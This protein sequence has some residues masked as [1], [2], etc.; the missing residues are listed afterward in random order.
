MHILVPQQK[1]PVLESCDLLVCGAGPGGVCAAVAAARRGARTVLLERWS[2]AGG[3]GTASLLAVWHTSDRTRQVIWGLVNEIFE[4]GSRHGWCRRLAHYPAYHETHEFDI[5]GLK[6][7]YDDL[8]TEAGVRVYYTLPAGDVVMDGA[9]IAAVLCDTKTGRKAIVPRQVI[10]ATGDGDIAAKAGAPFEVGRAQDGRV[11][12]MTLIYK[13]AGIDHVPVLKMSAAEHQ[14]ILD[15]MAAA[16]D[17]GELP[18][19]GPVSLGSYALGGYPNMNPCSGDP[20]DEAS[21]TRGLMQTRRQMHAYVEFWRRHAPGFANARVDFSA[22]ALGV[23]ESRRFLCRETLTAEDVRTRRKRPDAIG[24]GVWMVDIHDPLGSGHTT[25]QDG[26]YEPAGTSYHIPFG[27]LVPK[28]V[29]NLLIACRAAGSTHEGHASVRVMS[30]I[31]VIGQAAGTAAALTLAEG[32]NPGDVDVPMLQKAL[33]KDGVLIED[34]PARP[35]QQ[36]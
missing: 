12:G 23:R 25:W 27:M 5:E 32:I 14:A 15:A 11:Q 18:P 16:R 35:R 6:R 20:L 13:L 29:S 31:G 36:H 24:H 1:V 4:R 7:V 34:L 26:A 9:R 22:P 2:F 21:L 30:H 28:E 33:L 19:F 17:R 8:L 10:D 3:M